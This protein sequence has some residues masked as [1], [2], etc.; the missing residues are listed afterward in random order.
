MNRAGIVVIGR[1]EGERLKRSLQSLLKSKFPVLYVDSGSKDRSPEFALSIGIPVWKLDTKTPPNA[2]RARNAGFQHLMLSY[3]EME[4]VQFVDGDCFIA[5]N[6]MEAGLQ[7][8]G[9]H[10]EAAIVCGEIHELSKNLSVYDLL[11]EI[12][13]Q[14]PPGEISACGGVFMVRSSVFKEAE[15]F[16]PLLISAEDDDLCLRIRRMGWKILKLET[17]MAS[18][19]ADLGTFSRWWKR[20]V[21]CGYAYAQGAAKQGFGKEKHFVRQTFSTLFWGLMLPAASLFFIPW[22]HG[23]S[24]LLL[25]GYPLLFSKI[26]FHTI[27]KWPRKESLA[28]SGFC[29]LAKF[30]QLSGIAKF[31][32]D[33]LRGIDSKII[34]YKDS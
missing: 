5:E 8:L 9:K 2:S 17:P 12:E 1:N 24:L 11:C 21:R 4:Y 26:Y 6:W 10:P 23:W 3:P 30:S 27:K 18:H 13:W 15:G 29:V 14:K 32:F 20:S 33:K 16:D 7:A 34:E 25:L 22:T 19:E 31:A 28:Y